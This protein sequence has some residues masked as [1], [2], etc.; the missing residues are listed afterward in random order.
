MRPPG[1]YPKRSRPRSCRNVCNQAPRFRS[2]RFD[3]VVGESGQCRCDSAHALVVLSKG[4]T[5]DVLAR[6]AKATEEAMKDRHT[7]I[8][9]VWVLLLMPVGLSATESIRNSVSAVSAACALVLLVIAARGC[10]ISLR[11]VMFNAP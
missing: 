8:A 1:T 2:V 3:H 7:L 11:K 6:R 4:R 9:D 5:A 10:V